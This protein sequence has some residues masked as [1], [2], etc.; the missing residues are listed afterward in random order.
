MADAVA[1]SERIEV[2]TGNGGEGSVER[3]MG[4]GEGGAGRREGS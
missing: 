1:S 3:E 4:G 2:E